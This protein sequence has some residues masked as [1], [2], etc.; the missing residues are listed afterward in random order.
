[1]TG[2]EVRPVG[3]RALL[4]GCAD[5][6]EVLGLHAALTAA[7][8]PGQA[9]VL[10]AARTVLVR[11]TDR[12]ARDRLAPVLRDLPAPPAPPPA[13]EVV[14]LDTVYDGADL[15]F[16]AEHTGLSVEGVV[17]AHSG[18]E[19]TAAFGG[20][21][22][23][24]AYLV[25]PTTLA[26]PRR[27]SPRTAVPAGSVALAGTFSAVY[28]RSSP[29]GWQLLGHTD[30]PVWDLDRQPP[31][32][33]RPGDRVRFRPVRER[34]T[35]RR[36]RPPARAAAAPGPALTV[37][38][39]GAQSLLEDLGRSG[40]LDLGVSPSGAADRGSARQ[41]NRLVGNDRAAAVVE[42]VLGGLELRATGHHVLAVSGAPVPL[43]LLHDGE[44]LAHPPTD[45]PFLLPDGHV[46]RLGHPAVGL[47]AYVAVRG[48]ITVPPVLGSRSTDLLSGTGPPP[49]APG[50]VLPVGPPPATAVGQPE[51]G[52]VGAPGVLRVGVVLGPRADRVTP[53]SLERLLSQEWT[54]SDRSN[55]VGLRLDG[56][57]LQRADDSELPSEGTVAGAV[58]LPSDGRPVVFLADHPVTGG[59]PV[60]AVVREA[61]RDV[62]AQARP[63]DRLVFRD[64]IPPCGNVAR[65]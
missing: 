16:V 30:A 55:R 41:A 31:A 5:L 36:S 48:G 33:L 53:E 57:P 25:G 44:E 61:D 27:A 9:E 42:T 60:L 28:P 19:W 7:P 52:R 2:R 64:A 51:P 32:L 26:V 45:A 10:A 49:L 46:L 11:A 13:G 6:A 4:V 34:V 50:T 37:L 39:T 63:G 40:M 21:A 17:A 29:G 3:E 54:V 14:V 59:Y 56:V 12:A 47:R 58:Q 24:F 18:E 8:L 15:T 62:L 22:P 1:M 23:G 43:T 65:T 38:A 35:V 20:F